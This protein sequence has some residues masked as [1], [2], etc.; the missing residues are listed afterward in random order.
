MLQEGR[1]VLQE[2]EACVIGRCGLC[3]RRVRDVLEEGEG[4]V[5]GG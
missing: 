4:G 3:Y 5:R 1:V 2:A